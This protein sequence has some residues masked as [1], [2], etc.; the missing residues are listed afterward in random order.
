MRRTVALLAVM[1]A[2]LVV[3][4]G[5][6]LAQTLPEERSI[7]EARSIP[8]GTQPAA[9]EAIPGEY[10]VVLGNQPAGGGPEVRAADV[11][12]QMASRYAGLEVKQ[13]Y[14]HALDGFAARIPKERLD[15]V[16]ADPRVRFV[17]ENREVRAT[18]RQFLPEGVDRIEAD[19]SSTRAGN[20]AG[21][22]GV[23]IAVID[24]GVDRHPDLNV[25]GGK[26][27]TSSGGFDDDNGHGTHVAGTAAARDNAFGVVGVAP[28]A[29]IY[30]VRVLGERGFG[31]SAGVVCGIDWVTAHPGRI[32][33]A[34]MSLGGRGF[35]DESCGTENSDATHYAICRSVDEG[36]TYVVAAGNEK[37]DFKNAAPAAYDEV[38]TV[39]AMTDYNGE[40]GG[41]GRP[42]YDPCKR[43][44]K[45]FND[46][47]DR[48]STSFSNFTTPDSPDANHT[49]AAPGVCV[50]STYEDGG[51][52]L[53]SGTSMASP[54]VAGTAALY[55]ARNPDA[56]PQRVIDA[57][58]A[59]A[60]QQPPSYGFKGDPRHPI[61]KHYYGYLVHAGDF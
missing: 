42:A 33:V 60:K 2:A 49:I 44:P 55:K 35:D 11:A 8:S 12:R 17:S 22:V 16:K 30:A 25:A 54:H 39:T 32:E 43:Y 59:E 52:A 13:T 41:G 15:E 21:R 28:G 61:N 37:A 6:A 4:S 9:G 29:P 36:I 38:L 46:K 57:L 18:F 24:T 26:D 5:L 53:L 1:A 19:R 51:Y 58:R 31:T 48:V 56:S 45:R 34:N 10:I 47:D 40:P 20:G 50:A 27:C 7:P 3:A 14:E 23:G